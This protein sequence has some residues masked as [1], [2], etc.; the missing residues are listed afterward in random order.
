MMVIIM[1]SHVVAHCTQLQKLLA[2][3][4][5]LLDDNWSLHQLQTILA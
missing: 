5:A 3:I 2:A 4:D 1:I